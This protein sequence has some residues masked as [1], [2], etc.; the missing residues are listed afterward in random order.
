MIRIFFSR[1]QFL[2][3]CVLAA[4]SIASSA[5][6]LAVQPFQFAD[7]PA[8]ETLTGVGARID[9]ETAPDS[10]WA[11]DPLVKDIIQDEI[12]KTG[13][14]FAGAYYLAIVGCGSGCEA[15]FVIDSRDGKIFLVPE[16]STNGVRFQRDS[17]LIVIK[18]DSNFGS[19][20]KYLVFDGASFAEID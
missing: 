2:R 8:V 14:N 11:L 15:L 18:E 5:S 20:R 9:E 6:G 12:A 16:S 7:F 13:P 4:V 3:G 17:R 19:P 10:W 1:S